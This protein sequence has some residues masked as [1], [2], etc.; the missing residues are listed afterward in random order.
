MPCM[1]LRLHAFMRRQL[2]HACTTHAL[3]AAPHQHAPQHK[4][5]STQPQP[6]SITIPEIRAHPWFNRT[7]PPLYQHALDQLAAEQAAIDQ[8]V[9]SGAYVSKDRD[10]ALKTMIYLAASRFNPEQEE[11]FTM[12]SGGGGGGA[13]GSGERGALR[14]ISLTTLMP[15]QYKEVQA[16]RHPDLATISKFFRES[17]A[18][19]DAADAAA[20][21]AAAAARRRASGEAAAAGAAAGAAAASG[22]G[23][24]NGAPVAATSSGASVA[25]AGSGAA[26]AAAGSGEVRAAAAEAAPAAPVAAAEAAAKE[27]AAEVTAADSKQ[28]PPSK[29]QQQQDKKKGKQDNKKGK[30]EQ[31]QQQQVAQ[32]AKA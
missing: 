2:L 14:K 24:A 23:E 13:G 25:A 11:G 12:G 4:P 29:Q 26:V 28:Q 20:A 19:A 1:P 8:K 15:A 9:A 3:N 30:G 21:A 18:A 22:G 16:A 17:A 32:P 5:Q 7:L 27:V 10:S 31:Q 6:N